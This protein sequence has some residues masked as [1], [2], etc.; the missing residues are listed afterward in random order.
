M[1]SANN[2]AATAIAPLDEAATA[3]VTVNVRRT[4]DTSLEEPVANVQRTPTVVEEQDA[5]IMFAT[6]VQERPTATAAATSVAPT[7]TVAVARLAVVIDVRV[8]RANT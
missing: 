1:A 2:V 8:L 6:V 7:V 4:R 3:T 5:T